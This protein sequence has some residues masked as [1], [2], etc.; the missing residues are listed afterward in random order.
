M[1]KRDRRSFLKK[2]ALGGAAAGIGMAVESIFPRRTIA[3]GTGFQRIYYRELGSTGYK[4]S[5]IGFGAMNT[6]DAEL[7]H[8]AIDGGINYLDTAHS[9]MQGVNEEIVGTVMK[10]K[11]NKVFLAT[12]LRQV[13]ASE[14]PGLME[15]SLKRLN[16][17]HVDLVL[18]HITESREQALN[19]DYLKTFSD[20]K[21]KGMTRFIGLSTHKNQA[22]VIDAAISSKVWDAVL[23]GYNYSSPPEVG[24]AIERARKA[25]LATIAMKIMLSIDSRKP[26]DTPAD[27]RK[28]K[29]NAAQSALRWV[30]QNPYVDTTV[31]GMTAFEHLA[32]DLAVMGTKMSFF[33]RRTL[34]RYAEA[35]SK[36]NCRG[37]A[38]CTGCQGQCPYGVEICDL[39][40]CVGYA[41]GYGDLALARENYSQLPPSS[42]VE[43]CSG[44]D[45]CLVKCVNGL[46]LNRTIRHA[47]ELFG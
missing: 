6:R 10:T 37:S 22:E 16:T 31:P 18:L 24:Q 30:L 45:R 8:A 33:D 3:Q 1:E 43:A 17:D 41:Y 38:G 35:R 23:V 7:I 25:G 32:E 44:C 46:D 21:K 27:L 34:T 28:G 15:L 9:Y 5:E 40:R 20:L 26:L 13:N 47:R 19:A 12:K 42:R 2:A 11:R 14:L 4:A 39:N 36:G 29:M